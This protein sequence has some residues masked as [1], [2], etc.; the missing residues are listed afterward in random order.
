MYQGI[1]HAQAIS[2]MKAG[3][4]SLLKYTDPFKFNSSASSFHNTYLNLLLTDLF[5]SPLTYYLEIRKYAA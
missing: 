4:F 3:I 1:F 2:L 5:V